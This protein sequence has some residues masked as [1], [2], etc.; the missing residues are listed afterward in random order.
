MRVS[1]I[2]RMD[3]QTGRDGTRQAREI[4][5]RP[6]RAVM[7]RC[8]HCPA[9]ESEAEIRTMMVRGLARRMGGSHR[10]CQNR[11]RDRDGG[12]CQCLSHTYVVALLHKHPDCARAAL[13]S[14]I[15]IYSPRYCACG[16]TCILTC[17]RAC[18]G[19]GVACWGDFL[20]HIDR[21][22]LHVRGG[23]IEYD[24][25]RPDSRK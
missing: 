13:L 20:P 19:A 6:G 2:R 17:P 8:S 14:Y 21:L 23:S 10:K 24:S 7:S 15:Y 16:S 12:A 18:G 22:R 9:D 11:D 3:V 5:Q 25:V 4:A 1:R